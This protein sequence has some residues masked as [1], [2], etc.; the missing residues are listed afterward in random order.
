MSAYCAHSN[1]RSAAAHNIHSLP[2]WNQVLFGIL[3]ISADRLRY[4]LHHTISV[5]IEILCVSAMRTD[6]RTETGP[7]CLWSNALENVYAYKK[8]AEPQQGSPWTAHMGRAS[9][10]TAEVE[11]QVEL[12]LIAYIALLLR[13]DRIHVEFEHTFFLPPTGIIGIMKSFFT[14]SHQNISSWLKVI[15]GAHS[16][17]QPKYVLQVMNCGF[18]TYTNSTFSNLQIQFLLFKYSF[19]WAVCFHLQMWASSVRTTSTSWSITRISS[20]YSFT[21]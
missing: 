1:W 21:E 2:N 15:D 6:N 20:I 12:H 8:H 7:K 5:F 11:Y 3:Y 10:L 16:M 9:N 17:Q 19:N 14:T 4:A 13:W 18:R